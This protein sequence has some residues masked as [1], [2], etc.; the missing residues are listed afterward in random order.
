VDFG[1]NEVIPPPPI[2]TFVGE[3]QPNPHRSQRV[4]LHFGKTGDLRFLGHLDLLRL[5]DRA[6]R[7][8]SFPMAYSGGFHPMPRMI[9]ASA[10]SLGLTS[11]GELMDL[12]LT[13][14]IA[15]ALLFQQLQAQL[16]AD[17]PLYGVTDIPLTDPPVT[18]AVQEAR[19]RVQV[20]IVNDAGER[21]PLSE[22]QWHGWVNQ[23]L[24]RSL[25]EIELTTKSGKTRIVNL[26]DRLQS[27]AIIGFSTHHLASEE[28]LE[29]PA[30]VLE[31]QGAYRNDGTLLRPEH[32]VL[33]L[34]TIAQESMPD[35]KFQIQLLHAH[36]V[37]IVL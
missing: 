16:P 17:I 35:E 24:E 31:Y 2:P 32:L 7:R 29:T 21:F 18:E 34:E 5:F 8:A 26:R 6:V 30:I 36:R 4:R 25:I 3:F 14:T 13:E 9:P 19:Y 15:P 22:D 28:P 1:H 11:E 27:L 20:T 12:E 33:L 37:A 23:V 10:L